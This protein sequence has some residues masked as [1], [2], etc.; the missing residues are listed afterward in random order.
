VGSPI[1]Y[2]EIKF[3]FNTAGVHQKS[4]LTKMPHRV[5]GEQNANGAPPSNRQVNIPI[6]KISDRNC[7]Q[8]K[9]IKHD[10]FIDLLRIIDPQNAA[11]LKGVK[12]ESTFKTTYSGLEDADRWLLGFAS[13]LSIYKLIPGQLCGARQLCEN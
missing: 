1:L 11:L 6:N 10:H 3:V 13:I 12:L 2:G 8:P 4:A 5:P 9:S 7:Y